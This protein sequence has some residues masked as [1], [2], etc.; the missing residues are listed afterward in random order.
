[1]E[2]HILLLKKKS[3]E[4]IICSFDLHDPFP[5]DPPHVQQFLFSRAYV[6][7]LGYTLSVEQTTIRVERGKHHPS[8]SPHVLQVKEFSYTSFF[9]LPHG[10]SI[11][12]SLP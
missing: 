1:M 2:D 10:E 5:L 7:I 6:W 12:D 8:W 9:S 11:M 4:D 3:D